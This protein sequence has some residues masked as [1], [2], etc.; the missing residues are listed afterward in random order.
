MAVFAAF[1]SAL[2]AAF[3]TAFFIAFV[4]ALIFG[5]FFWRIDYGRKFTQGA[6]YF[7]AAG[8]G[9]IHAIFITFIDRL[10]AAGVDHGGGD[11]AVYRLY[12]DQFRTQCSGKSPTAVLVF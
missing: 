4:V 1:I 8:Q 10:G 11:A 3:C 2:M 9:G 12:Q 6:A 7:A 5:A